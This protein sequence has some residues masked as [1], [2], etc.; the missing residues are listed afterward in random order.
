MRLV[1][2]PDFDGLV[3]AVFLKHVFPISSHYYV[4]PKLVQDGKVAI[5]PTDIIANL[6]YHPNCDWW[7]DHHATN[8]IPGQFK[9]IYE[10]AP[11]AAGLIY[12]A[13]HTIYPRLAK[14]KYLSDQTDIIDGALLSIDQVIHPSGYVLISFTLDETKFNDSAYWEH[15]IDRL[16]HLSEIECIAD[17]W[18][19][20]RIEAFQA[21][22]ESFKKLLIQQSKVVNEVLISDFRNVNDLPTMNRFLQYAMWPNVNISI[23]MRADEREKDRVVL[24][25]AKSIFNTTSTV[26]V[27]KILQ[28]F[29]G[30]GHQG[31]GST[32]ILA[33]DTDQILTEIL[34]LI[35]Y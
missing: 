14:H 2:R 1:L 16:E 24:K 13:Y 25:L 15:L 20:N 12:Q 21:G 3:C 17:P 34:H 33:S 28:G 29:G 26:H 11:S 35:K 8:E 4:E 30:G 18:I 5:L 31:A 6:P 32:R 10:L 9:G 23:T 19:K 27:G 7:F 22:Q